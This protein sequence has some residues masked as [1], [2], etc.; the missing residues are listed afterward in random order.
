MTQNY[1]MVGQVASIFG[2]STKTIRRW[3]RTVPNFPKPR[4]VGRSLLF[5]RAEIEAYLRDLPCA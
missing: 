5:V 1:L 3:V 2:K 4:K